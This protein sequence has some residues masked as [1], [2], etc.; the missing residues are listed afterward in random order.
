MA[1]DRK[2][3]K[4]SRARV[5]CEFRKRVT[6]S[7]TLKVTISAGPCSS[8][9]NRALALCSMVNNAGTEGAGRMRFSGVVPCKM[10]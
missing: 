4:A 8:R 6:V 10:K 9:Q 2:D 3:G 1:S 5:G 7:G